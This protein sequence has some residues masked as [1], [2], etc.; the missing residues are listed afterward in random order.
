MKKITLAFT[1]CALWTGTYVIEKTFE[2]FITNASGAYANN[3]NSTIP[4][5]GIKIALGARQRS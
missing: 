3:A 2:L 5:N 4:T 1:F